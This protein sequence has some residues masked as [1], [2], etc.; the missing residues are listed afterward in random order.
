MYPY[1]D[2]VV[3]A[4]GQPLLSI[5]LAYLKSLGLPLPHSGLGFMNALMLA[6]IPLS[7]LLLYRILRA[8]LVPVWSAVIGSLLI[9]F[10]SPQFERILAHYALSYGFIIPLYWYLLIKAFARTENYSWRPLALYV[11]VAFLAGLLHP[12]WVT[13]AALLALAYGFVALLQH[14]KASSYTKG[15]AGRVMLAGVLAVGIFQLFMAV[16]DSISDRPATPWGFLYYRSGFAS[17]FYPVLEPLRGFWKTALKAAPSEIWEGW[18]YVG[19]IGLVTLLLTIIRIVQYLIRLKPRLILKPVLPLPLR[20]GLHAGILCAL[21]ASGV[22]FI[23]DLTELL[24]YLQPLKQFRSIGRFAWIFYYIYTVYVV[25]YFSMLFRY[26]RTRRAGRFALSLAILLIVIWGWEGRNATASFAKRFPGAE[27]T[28][29]FMEPQDSYMAHLSWKHPASDFQAILPMPFYLIG[30]EVVQPGGGSSPYESMR[31]SLQTGLPLVSAYMSRA[32]RSRSAAILQL[33]SNDV[34]PKEVLHDFPNQKPL[35][36]LVTP[37][38][39]SKPERNLLSKARLLLTDKRVSLYELPLSALN[40]E[41][42]RRAALSALATYVPRPDVVRLQSWKPSAGRS[43]LGNSSIAGAGSLVL[44]KGTVPQAQDTTTYEASVWVRSVGMERLP[45]LHLRELDGQ[46]GQ[47]LRNQEIHF[48][49]ATDVYQGWLCNRLSTR[50]QH[51]TNRLEVYLDG[52]KFEAADVLI[53]PAYTDVY[54]T[55]AS[56][57]P[58]KNNLPLQD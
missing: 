22:P 4:D 46:T 52:E 31:A 17:I 33:L 56:G 37:D 30:S 44:W 34:L 29:D 42:Y 1:G 26:L 20:I 36:L 38:P 43:A 24:E 55:L 10:M 39:L 48:S 45:V 40:A 16:T 2:H 19:L 15:L 41:P 25:F 6:S 3:Y 9:S 35:L 28:Q 8:N 13:M 53:R 47:E 58:C 11:L 21:F 18:A 32:S 5:P 7:A 12:Y 54:E 57:R 49:Q 14:N 23:W 27:K 51:P 50:L